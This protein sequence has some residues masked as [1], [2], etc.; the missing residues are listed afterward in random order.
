MRSFLVQQQPL[1][2][3]FAAGSLAKLPETMATCAVARAVL[4]PTPSVRLAVGRI[5]GLLPERVAGSFEG[6][7]PHVP[8]SAVKA[9]QSFALSRDADC[10]IAIGGGAAIDL[11]KAAS[12]GT[13]LTVIAMPTTYGGSELTAHAGQVSDHKKQSIHSGAPRAVLYDPE[14]TYGL[15]RRATAGSAMNALAHCVEAL[16]APHPQP[17]AL[18][19]AEE[20]LRRIPPALR[21]VDHAPHDAEGRAELLF[22]AYLAG[23]ALAGTGMAL[24]HRICHVLGGR[25]GIAHGDANAIMLAHVV[26]FNEPFAQDEIATVARA[27]GTDDAAKALGALAR[28]AGAPASL[29][30]LGLD[31]AERETIADLVLSQPLNNPRP[32]GR[33]A[34]LRLL[35]GA[36]SRQLAPRQISA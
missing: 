31:L 33:E 15:P 21:I 16:Y 10:L 26:R 29:G 3:V 14:L 34:L 4:V 28:E 12:S 24:H 6:V 36:W 11:A 8:A 25:Y 18:L 2:V 32:V 9:L 20:A 7:A 13:G 1:E 30:E 23:V 19:A 27:L 5:M 35:D 22:G 17:L